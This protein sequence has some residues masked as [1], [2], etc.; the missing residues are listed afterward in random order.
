MG[1]SH[2]PY[3]ALNSEYYPVFCYHLDFQYS[4]NDWSVYKQLKLSDSLS[5]NCFITPLLLAATN[6]TICTLSSNCITVWT[7]MQKTNVFVNHVYW[8]SLLAHFLNHVAYVLWEHIKLSRRSNGSTSQLLKWRVQLYN[9]PILVHL[10]RVL[11][12]MVYK[13]MMGGTEY[14]I[15]VP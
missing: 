9:R 2:K 12:L 8:I 7:T 15:N 11:I 1:K 5:G 13:N 10:N 4:W 3:C 6:R 14:R